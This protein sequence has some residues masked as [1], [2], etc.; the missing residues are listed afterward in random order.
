MSA[1]EIEVRD[2]P[3][4][5]VAT[6]T[7]TAAGWGSQHIGPVVGPIFPEAEAL[8]TAAGVPFGPAIAIYREEGHGVAVTAGFALED[9]T[10]A[11][12]G[13]DVHVLPAVHAVVAT[14]HGSMA[15][16]DQAWEALMEAVEAQGASTAGGGREVYL[17]EGDVPQDQWVTELVQPITP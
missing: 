5:R 14:H 4:Q 16:I 10:Q 11:V 13:L 6:I 9:D 3:P 8:L 17:T 1:T 15:T 7:R 2:V 12:D